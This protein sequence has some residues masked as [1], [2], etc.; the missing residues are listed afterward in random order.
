MDDMHINRVGEAIYCNNSPFYETGVW[1][2]SG[3]LTGDLRELWQKTG[4]S[5]IV[6]PFNKAVYDKLDRILQEGGK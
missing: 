3:I 6:W 4:G 2:D 1:T 5:V